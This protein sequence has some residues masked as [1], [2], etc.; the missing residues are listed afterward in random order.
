MADSG[1][2]WSVVLMIANSVYQR[3]IPAPQGADILVKRAKN[4]LKTSNKF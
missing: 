3:G 4:R 1:Q 2:G